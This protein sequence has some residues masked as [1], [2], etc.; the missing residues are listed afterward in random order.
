MTCPAY[1]KINPVVPE[2]TRSPEDFVDAQLEVFQ[3]YGLVD[4]ITYQ[5][6][7]WRS[8]KLSKQILPSLKTVALAE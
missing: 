7:D 2:Q 6:F 1:R 5:S 4:R 3:K 8:I